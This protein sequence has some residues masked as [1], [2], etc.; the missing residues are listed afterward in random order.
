MFGDY[1]DSEDN[2]ISSINE[3]ERAEAHAKQEIDKELSRFKKQIED[4][5][6]VG[7]VTLE[8]QIEDAKKKAAIQIEKAKKEANHISEKTESEAKKR[9]DIM[10]NTRLSRNAEEEIIRSFV[11]RIVK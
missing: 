11:E 9:A 7:I 4:A 8:K 5:K 3:V 6:A 1:T 2:K 10:R